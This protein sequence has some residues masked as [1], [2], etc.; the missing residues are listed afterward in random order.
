MIFSLSEGPLPPGFLTIWYFLSVRVHYRQALSPAEKAR[1]NPI[2]HVAIFIPETHCF[3]IEN[4][5]CVTHTLNKSDPVQCTV[6]ILY[7]VQCI[8]CTVYSVYPVDVPY[9][10]TYRG[11]F[12]LYCS[13]PFAALR[14]LQVMKYSGRKTFVVTDRNIAHICSHG[15]DT[16][17]TFVVTD[18]IHCIPL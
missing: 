9:I 1:G 7:S 6:Y 14:L 8:S 15:Q 2:H 17:Q 3:L 5:Y 16:L 11:L 12:L 13:G 10:S 4:V 18:R